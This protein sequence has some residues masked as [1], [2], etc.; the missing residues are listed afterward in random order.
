M[1]PPKE[2]RP[3]L[4]VLIVEDDLDVRNTIA[5]VLEEEGHRVFV[6]ADGREALDLL[7]ATPNQPGLI[8]LD[9]MMPNMDGWQFIAEQRQQER[10]ARIP[11]VVL[12][13]YGSIPPAKLPIEVVDHI[14]K[15]IDLT[16]LLAVVQR[17]CGASAQG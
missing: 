6:A 8:L 7:L 5:E 1:T 11:V 4:P 3:V 10:L 13:A 14:R 16:T 17:F 2:S 9:L 12:S 15:P